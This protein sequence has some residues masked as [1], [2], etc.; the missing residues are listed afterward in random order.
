MN[1]LQW[2]TYELI[3]SVTVAVIISLFVFTV[4]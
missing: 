2:Q 1:Q 4:V 3:A